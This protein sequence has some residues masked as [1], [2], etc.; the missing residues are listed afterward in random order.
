MQH[1]AT[2]I[3]VWR[4]FD[5][6]RINR[7]S[8][9]ADAITL[10]TAQYA[11][12]EDFLERF[13]SVLEAL[14]STISPTTRSRV[15]VRYV[16]RIQEERDLGLLV[17]LIQPE[18]LNVMQ[19]ELLQQIDF[20]MTDIACQTKEGRLIVRFGMA[21]PKFTHDQDVLPAVENPSWVLDIDSISTK[22]E[23]N[24]FDP[25]FL[26]RELDKMA[27]RAYAF[28]RWAITDEFLQH[29]GAVENE[30]SMAVAAMSLFGGQAITECLVRSD[31]EQVRAVETPF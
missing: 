15:G 5:L 17:K 13:K 21:P 24:K 10:E 1:R 2:E 30:D 4:F 28:F 19:P 22:Y 31:M 8:L 26:S 3:V 16:H 23:G 12:R 25:E 18:L 27:A 11:S 6:K 14:S 29:F 7:V 20:S 9:A